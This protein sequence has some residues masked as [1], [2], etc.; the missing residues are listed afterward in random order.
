[1]DIS[2]DKFERDR[3][4]MIKMD[5]LVHESGR[6][7]LR[8]TGHNKCDIYFLPNGDLISECADTGYALSL[9]NHL[10]PLVDDLDIGYTGK[11]NCGPYEGV[12]A[13]STERVGAAIKRANEEYRESRKRENVELL[14]AKARTY[15]MNRKQKNEKVES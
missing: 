3:K 10:L 6:F 14:L 13:A 1:M 5:C 7:A 11:M 15:R 4:T 9:I 2:L 12:D 8:V